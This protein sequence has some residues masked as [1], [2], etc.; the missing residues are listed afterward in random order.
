MKK[1]V[2][3]IG[4]FLL[5]IS[6]S[7]DDNSPKLHYELLK[8]DS[9]ELPTDFIINEEN[10]IQINFIRPSNCYGFDGF[11]Y[12]KNEFTRTVAV[13]GIVFDRD[14]CTPLS[15]PISSQTLHFTPTVSGTYTFKF[16]KGKDANNVDI[17]EEISIVVP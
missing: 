3:L 2:A 9:V 17:F 7:V 15:N 16:W 6:C 8:I 1:I 5:S 13:Q 4:I 11:Y 12:E 10:D 14:N